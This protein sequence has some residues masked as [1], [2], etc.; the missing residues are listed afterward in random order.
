MSKKRRVSPAPGKWVPRSATGPSRVKPGKL[1][2][3]TETG[4]R[5]RPDPEGSGLC[6]L[7]RDQRGRIRLDN[8]GIA[9]F[10]SIRQG[11]V[12]SELATRNSQVF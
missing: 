4:L 8:G 3:K 11:P 12:A 5:K 10:G 9:K 1:Y 7:E 6:D 2:S